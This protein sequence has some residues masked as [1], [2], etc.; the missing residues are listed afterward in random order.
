[1]AAKVVKEI[2]EISK[3]TLL[4]FGLITIVI[5][6]LFF[7]LFTKTNLDKNN[8]SFQATFNTV[9][10]LSEKSTV[11]YAGIEVGY[12]TQITLLENNKVR[13]NGLIKNEIPIPSDSILQINTDGIFGKKYL[14]IV[15]GYDEYFVSKDIVFKYTSDSYTMDYLAR[16]LENNIN[17]KN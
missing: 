2:D 14:N 11:L 10:G 17:E 1:M 12:V 6:L 16:V 8:F 9:N 13:I 15:P 7:F 4:K 3:N 5:F